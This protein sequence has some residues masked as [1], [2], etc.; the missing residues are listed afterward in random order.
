MIKLKR[1][2][3]TQSSSLSLPVWWK[4]HLNGR[5]MDVGK[6]FKFC[7]NRF[8]Y[9]LWKEKKGRYWN[10]ACVALAV[11]EPGTDDMMMTDVGK[12]PEK[13]DKL[14]LLLLLLL[15]AECSSTTSTTTCSM[16]WWPFRFSVWLKP[17]WINLTVSSLLEASESGLMKPLPPFSQRG[18]SEP[19]IFYPCWL[20]DALLYNEIFPFFLLRA[21]KKSDMIVRLYSLQP[22]DIFRAHQQ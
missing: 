2:R 5:I 13:K 17:C 10:M 15:H 6:I 14:L 3:E 4:S 22:I 16:C 9:I 8:H 20:R 1:N 19:V 7:M 18:R 21:R 11:K 12:H